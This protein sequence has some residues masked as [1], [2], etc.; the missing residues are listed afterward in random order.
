M[1]GTA[2]S[3]SDV[4]VG[5]DK[6]SLSLLCTIE[7]DS[8]FREAIFAA[9]PVPSLALARTLGT[10]AVG[11]RAIP[12]CVV[13]CPSPNSDSAHYGFD[14]SQCG[15]DSA[16]RPPQIY[17][18]AEHPLGSFHIAP[19]AWRIAVPLLVRVL[20]LDTLTAFRIQTLMFLICTGVLLYYT[21]LAAGYPGTEALLGLIMFWSYGAAT[22]LLLGEPYTP[23][24]ASFALSLAALY[25]LFKDHDLLLATAL[26]AG[27]C[28]KETSVLVIPLVYTIRARQLFDVRLMV[29]TILVA[30]PSLVIL[31]AIRDWIAPYNDV[32]SYIEQLGTQLTQVQL[33]TT[34]FG[35]MD[36]LRLVTHFRLQDTAVNNFRD[37]T[38]GNVGLLWLLPFFAMRSPAPPGDF[39]DTNRL[40]ARSNFSLALRFAPFLA[41]T[42]FGWFMALNADRRFAFAFPFWI[43]MSLNGVRSLAASWE[44]N[45]EWF[46]PIFLFQYF[47]NLLQPRTPSVPVDIALGMFLLTLG[48]LFCFR[49]QLRRTP[50]CTVG[51]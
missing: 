46:I 40:S 18:M 50:K 44:I 42:Y 39:Q 17:Y 30:L 34:R 48:V 38:F 36:S 15:L 23:D 35:F 24:P 43:M 10:L 11:S 5:T 31:V 12:H 27:V 32:P 1:H 45:I 22:K 21:L 6:N 49:E 29:R 33:G 41:L 9:G 16:I 25:F 26:A 28:V 19:P 2:C 8:I 47:L 20:P 13:C 7:D 37:L 51:K 4:F 14:A 3:G